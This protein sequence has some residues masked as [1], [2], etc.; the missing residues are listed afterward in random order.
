MTKKPALRLAGKEEKKNIQRETQIK[1]PAGE[2]MIGNVRLETKEDTEESGLFSDSRP[3]CRGKL[4]SPRND[5]T[6]MFTAVKKT[7]TCDKCNKEYNTLN[8]LEFHKVCEHE[9]PNKHARVGNEKRVLGRSG[10]SVRTVVLRKE[11]SLVNET[12]RPPPKSSPWHALLSQAAR[13][14]RT[15]DAQAIRKIRMKLPPEK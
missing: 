11:D 3:E 1:I 13:H 2:S 5:P 4:F 6:E 15:E 10:K 14:F 8:R 12:S 9:K 7:F